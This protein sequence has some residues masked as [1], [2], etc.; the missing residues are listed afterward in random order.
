MYAGVRA[1]GTSNEPDVKLLRAPHYV[2]APRDPV[3]GRS[4]VAAKE[5]PKPL[6]TPLPTLSSFFWHPALEM[7]PSPNTPSSRRRQ[8]ASPPPRRK[9]D[10]RLSLGV[11][12]M[13]SD[14]AMV[15]AHDTLCERF[16]K[17]LNDATP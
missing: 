12:L 17:R 7:Q 16:T 3:F 2:R 4:R 9:P 6:R 1:L 8:P 10:H 11:R 14:T 5:S 15:L 13:P